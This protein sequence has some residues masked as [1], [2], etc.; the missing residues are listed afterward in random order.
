MKAFDIIEKDAG[1]DLKKL[2]YLMASDLYNCCDPKGKM[3]CLEIVESEYNRF[4]INNNGV[5]LFSIESNE[6]RYH[7]ELIAPEYSLLQALECLKTQYNIN[8]KHYKLEHKYGGG[9]VYILTSL[10]RQ[11]VMLVSIYFQFL[12]EE[13][14]DESISL[15]PDEMIGL[16][17]GK[18]DIRL[19]PF[20]SEKEME[21]ADD[22]PIDLYWARENLCG[23][24]QKWQQ[25]IEEKY[26]LNKEKIINE[27]QH[28]EIIGGFK[29]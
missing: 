14:L 5:E 19:D 15:T 3:G 12:C 29:K 21:I 16:L 28:L 18:C 6:T 26:S 20:I 7:L 25:E 2:V 17:Y 23:P 11:S 13:V 4:L 1:D 9:T 10:D 22:N 8:V 24:D 27:I